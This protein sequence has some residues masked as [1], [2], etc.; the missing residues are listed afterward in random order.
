M[1]LVQI[2]VEASAIMGGLPSTWP[3]QPVFGWYYSQRFAFIQI[4]LSG[5]ALECV[6]LGQ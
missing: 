1:N 6:A 5:D 3:T 2:V 4:R